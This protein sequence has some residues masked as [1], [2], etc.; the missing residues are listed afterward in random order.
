M[1]RISLSSAWDETRAFLTREWSLALPVTLATIGLGTLIFSLA[2]PASPAGSM[3]PPQPGPWTLLVI[4][5][6]L[7]QL[8]GTLALSALVLRS[9]RSVGEALATGGRKLGVGILAML[10][11]AL[12]GLAAVI[13]P[14]VLGTFLGIALGLTQAQTLAFSL[15]VLVPLLLWVYTRLLLVAALIV[16]RDAGPIAALRGSW[17][18]TRPIAWRLLALMIAVLVVVII[19]SSAVQVTFGSLFLLLGRLLAS[20]TLGPWL[21][22]VLLAAVAAVLQGM[23]VVYLAMLYRR[24]SSGT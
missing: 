24:L 21:V 13:I 1:T 22:Q 23:F 19:L 15:V 12:L 11:Q 3:Q 18:L 2:V 4:P 20:E 17:A 5:Y 6:A 14:V 16:D 7:L 8:F 9:G 10:L